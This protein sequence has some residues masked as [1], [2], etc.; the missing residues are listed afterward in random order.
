MQPG[1]PV[2]YFLLTFKYP[3]LSYDDVELT[4]LILSCAQYQSQWSQKHI[5]NPRFHTN[6]TQFRGSN[7]DLRC[8][9]FLV[10][11]LGMCVRLCDIMTLE[12][13]TNHASQECHIVL[14]NWKITS[15]GWLQ[16]ESASSYCMCRVSIKIYAAIV[17]I[18][19]YTVFQKTCDCIFNN[20]T[21]IRDNQ[22]Q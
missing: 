11:K 16:N 7:N 19:T 22:F 2:Q 9:A 15:V 6:Y 21:W 5:S 12:T 10:R 8:Q 20:I 3:L 4:Y 14:N 18:T 13:Y 1:V 17:N